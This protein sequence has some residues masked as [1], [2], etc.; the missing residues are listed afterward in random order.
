MN[1]PTSAKQKRSVALTDREHSSLK[2]YRERFST[3][4]DCALSIGVDRLVLNRVILVGS[5]APVSIKKIKK[6]LQRD[7]GRIK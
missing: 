7:A 5:G 4:V 1:A 6:A 2:A 3:E